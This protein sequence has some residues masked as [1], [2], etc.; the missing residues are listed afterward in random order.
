MTND[1]TTAEGGELLPL[2][3]T[4]P[5]GKPWTVEGY[6]AAAIRREIA[7]AR[8]QALREAVECLRKNQA[9]ILEGAAALAARG[10]E[11]SAKI[12][13]EMAEEW[14]EAADAIAALAKDGG[15]EAERHALDR[16]AKP[17]TTSDVRAAMEE[18]FG[19]QVDHDALNR[20]LAKDGG[21][22][23]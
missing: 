11:R 7:A 20:A 14:G 10:D 21:S 8:A 3:L 19:D 13:R 5:D 9:G 6:L 22:D 16:G 2:I 12:N 23:V 1:P 18:A 17:A 15:S 4:R